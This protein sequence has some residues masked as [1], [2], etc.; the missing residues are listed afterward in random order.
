MN[1]MRRW[2]SLPLAPP[3]PRELDIARHRLGRRPA[4][5]PWAQL[6]RTSEQLPLFG[7][8]RVDYPLSALPHP[9]PPPAPA[10]PP[11]DNPGCTIGYPSAAE[12]PQAVPRWPYVRAEAL[13][14]YQRQE[15][16]PYGLKAAQE[17]K[18]QARHGLQYSSKTAQYATAT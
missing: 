17:R 15:E 13:S 3:A 7:I 11:S 6:Y 8:P 9:L 2:S 1:D 10:R 4:Q 16:L 18:S 14:H 5:E 12:G